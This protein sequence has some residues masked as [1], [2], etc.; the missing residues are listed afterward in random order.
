MWLA[1][2]EQCIGLAVAQRMINGTQ[3][4]LFVTPIEGGGTS[5]VI[6]AIRPWP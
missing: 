6:R 4:E 1:C 5:I 3:T 2:G